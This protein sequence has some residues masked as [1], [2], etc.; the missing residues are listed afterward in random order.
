MMV[1]SILGL[2]V[3]VLWGGG[4]LYSHR[5]ARFIGE[6]PARI[7]PAIRR[8]DGRDFVPTPTPVVFAHHFAS[9]A[10][11]G[12]ILG[13]VMAVAYGWLPAILWVVLGGVFIGGVH[14]YLATYMATREDGESI[15]V[16]A[17]KLLGKDAFVAIVLFLIVMLA[18]VCS[19]FLV[20]SATALV[21]MIPFDRIELPVD[22][23]LFNTT[24]DLVTGRPQQVIIG[25]IASMSV[26]VITVIAP[27]LGWLYV[28]K[29]VPVWICSILALGICA[30][31]ICIGIYYPVS[32]P[33]HTSLLGMEITS[34]QLWMY[35]LSAYVLV[36]AGVPVWIFLQ[37]RDF[38]NVHILYVGMFA[39]MVTLLKASFAPAIDGGLPAVNVQE[40]AQAIGM[41]LWP[42]L[43]ITIACG[44]VSGFHCLCAGGTTCKQIKS[45][46][47]ARRIGYY[48]MLLESFLAVCVICAMLLGS[49]RIGYLTDVHPQILELT[50]KGNP[51]L[52]FAMA[53]GHTAKLAW[54]IPIAVGALAGMVLLE[55]FLVTTLDTAIRLTRYLIEEVWRAMFSHTD[56][57]ASRAS[58]QAT[59]F[60]TG[61]APTGADGIPMV[62]EIGQ[63]KDTGRIVATHGIYRAALL[64]LKQ[65]WVNS[66]LAV[67]LMLL[68]AMSGGFKTLWPIFATSNQL[69]AAILLGLATLWLLRRGHKV[70]FALIPALAMLATAGASLW[71]LLI[72]FGR[73][74]NIPLLVADWVLIAITLYFIYAV[75]REFL[76][77]FIQKVIREELSR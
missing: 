67:I 26:I 57:F 71:Q 75:S 32:F 40:G 55:G 50:S 3:L 70:W 43:F 10:G 69:L 12:P 1:L 77:W 28:K 48:G 46:V 58:A 72:E 64:V 8:E 25:G 39:L 24:R 9:I 29:K 45:E 63:P 11:A 53:I 38:I 4:W 13:P 31:S 19:A 42:G 61:E 23:T 6:D 74:K 66:G 49:T 30:A 17:R 52:G 27:L 2:S 16:I 56:V 54:N 34:S 21:S 5:I 65:Y 44:A 51:I 76:R 73:Q 68:L 14:D 37:S 35:L 41:P 7:T 20:A 15:A 18:L 47:A 59:P 62:I 33:D 36:A 60:I 22:Q